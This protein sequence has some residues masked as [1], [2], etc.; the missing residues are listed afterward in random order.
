[1]NS[2]IIWIPV[3]LLAMFFN[4]GK[5]LI[6]KTRCK[7][8]DPLLLVFYARLLPALLFLPYII[9]SKYS[10]TNSPAFWPAVLAASVITIAASLLYVSALQKGNLLVVVPIQAAIPLFMILTTMVLFG[11]VPPPSSLIFILLVSVSVGY[12]YKNT[13]G[14][15]SRNRAQ[16]LWSPALY[17]LSAAAL[18]GV[19]TVMDRIAISAAVPGAV[20]FTAY[21]HFITVI[22]L[23]PSF[24]QKIRSGP[25]EFPRSG[26]TG[27][28][29][30]TALLAFLFQQY[31]VQLSLPLENGV[32]YVKTLV[33][34]HIIFASLLGAWL[35]R[36]KIQKDLALAGIGA[37]AGGI[38]LI[39]SI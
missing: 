36:E 10:L 30:I 37:F 28:F 24:I 32:T 25:F 4:I 8:I 21:W 18:F 14:R 11:E 17:S 2:S 39:L 3:S 13:P 26:S 5:V 31:G 6:V 29:A 23:F 22:L 34:T 16:S 15:K 1:M 7:H 38:G 27:I 19:S 20:V 9:F 12:L 33:M 35:T